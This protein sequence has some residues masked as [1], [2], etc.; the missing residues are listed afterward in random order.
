MKVYT[1]AP[2]VELFLNGKSLGIKKE[3]VPGA[4]PSPPRMGSCLPA[5]NTEGGGT[6]RGE[7]LTDERKT[8]GPPAR[9][10]LES[11]VPQVNSGDRESL[12][13]ITAKVVDREGTVVPGAFNTIAF[14]S[15]VRVSCCRKPGRATEPALPGRPSPA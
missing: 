11:D 13:Y 2:E 4:P 10:V 7:A 15:T 6:F 1:N 5:R 3:G 8:A 14:N 12:A 9:I